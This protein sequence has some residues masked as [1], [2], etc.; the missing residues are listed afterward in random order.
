MQ[1]KRLFLH[2][3]YLH[4]YNSV[5][6]IIESMAGIDPHKVVDTKLLKNLDD[7]IQSPECK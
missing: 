4:I 3:H 1:D 5:H 7:I 2:I 6:V